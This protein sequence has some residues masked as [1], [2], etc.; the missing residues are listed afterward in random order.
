MNPT[1]VAPQ[2]TT[3]RR[4]FTKRI[5]E[6]VVKPIQIGVD[7]EDIELHQTGDLEYYLVIRSRQ[8][9]TFQVEL[10]H[11]GTNRLEALLAGVNDR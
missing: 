2:P 9:I 3:G 11:V 7:A 10:D 6:T 1:T 5:T 8:G 4:S